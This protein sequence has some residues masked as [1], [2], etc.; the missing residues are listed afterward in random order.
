MLPEDTRSLW[1]DF[2]DREGTS[3]LNTETVLGTVSLWL[4]SRNLTLGPVLHSYLETQSP[5]TGLPHW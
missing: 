4:E 3:L 5:K 2:G 1:K